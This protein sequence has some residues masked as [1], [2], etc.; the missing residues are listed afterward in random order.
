MGKTFNEL[1]LVAR[2][3]YEIRRDVAPYIGISRT[4]KFGDAADFAR[5]EGRDVDKLNFLVGIQFW[6]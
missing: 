2:L 4:K 5:A 3:R 1:E 6:F